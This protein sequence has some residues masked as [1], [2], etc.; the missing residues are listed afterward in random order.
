MGEILI[1]GLSEIKF[2]VSNENN[3]QD[4]RTKL[5]YDDLKQYIDSIGTIPEPIKEARE[6]FEKLA[7]AMTALSFGKQKVVINEICSV[8][9]NERQYKNKRK[10]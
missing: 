9:P 3:N 1:I 7:T 2:S 5:T 6:E 4:Q 10:W 8:N